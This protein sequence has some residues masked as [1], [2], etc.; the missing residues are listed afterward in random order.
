MQSG[1]VSVWVPIVVGLIG[2]VGVLLG[3]LLSTW[4]ERGNDA[5]RAR[6]EIEQEQRRNR[7]DDELHWRD[8]RI[9]VGVDLLIALN[10]WRELAVDAWEETARNGDATDGTRVA[11]SQSVIRVSDQLAHVRLVGSRLMASTAST[12]V[13]DLLATSRDTLDAIREPSD[14]RP[15]LQVASAQLSAGVRRVRDVFRTEAGVPDA[16]GGETDGGA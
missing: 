15:D 8:R 4:R 3:Q 6:R 2:V 5:I 9:E 12:I 14:V 1:Q 16:G 13:T 11:L 7:R 10:T